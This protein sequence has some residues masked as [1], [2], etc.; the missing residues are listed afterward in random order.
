[1]STIRVARLEPYP[2]ENPTGWVV[3]F[4]VS[5]EGKDFYEVTTS[6]YDEAK[7][8]EE[9]VDVAYEKLMYYLFDLNAFELETFER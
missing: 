4:N 1:M 9:A 5:V 2:S 3:G 6:T 7:N 8:E